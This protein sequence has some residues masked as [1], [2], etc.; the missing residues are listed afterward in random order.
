MG[1]SPFSADRLHLHHVLMDMGL[2]PRASTYVLLAISFVYGLFG[3]LGYIFGLPDWILFATFLGVLGIH[4]MFVFL[5]HRHA[6]SEP[7]RL[8]AD[9]VIQ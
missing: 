9:S 6:A 5:A 8:H 3:L 2:T 4:A 1:R 7:M